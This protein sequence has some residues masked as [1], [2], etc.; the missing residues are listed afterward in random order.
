MRPLTAWV[1]RDDRDAAVSFEMEVGVMA[2]FLGEG[3][4]LVEEVDCRP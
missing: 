4:D 1:H 2:F 3:G